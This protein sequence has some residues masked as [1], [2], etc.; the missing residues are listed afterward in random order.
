[1]K[2]SELFRL[3]QIAVLN[4]NCISPE[5]KLDILHLLKKEEDFA[6]WSEEAK[7]KKAAIEE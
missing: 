7:A 4:T 6:A 1:M 2:K 5:N 3:A